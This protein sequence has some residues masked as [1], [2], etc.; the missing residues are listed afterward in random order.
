MTN[1]IPGDRA[2]IIR[3]DVLPNVG[4]IVEVIREYRDGEVLEGDDTPYHRPEGLADPAWV[5]APLSNGALRVMVL[6]KLDGRWAEYQTV[7][8]DV[9][10]IADSRLRRLPRPDEMPE[11]D[12]VVQGRPVESADVRH[13]EAERNDVATTP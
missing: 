10:A 4:R 8:R 1:V 5:V 9:I 12:L 13:L 7:E 2:V 11:E 6:H 3:H